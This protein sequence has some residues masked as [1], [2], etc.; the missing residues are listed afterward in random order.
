MAKSNSFDVVSKTDLNEVLNAVNQVMKEVRTR[1]DF[2]GSSSSVQL[3]NQTLMLAGD[4]AYKLQSLTEILQQKLVKRGVSLKALSYGKVENASGGT[5]RQ[6]I[7]IQQGIPTEKAREI[8]KFVRD[9]KIKVQAS[10]QGDLVRVS[11]RDRDTLQAVI[12][13]L[14]EKDFGI[15]MHFTNYRSS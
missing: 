5:V 7:S 6:Q 15:D 3:E 4:D 2:K 13:E 1:F 12:R 9:L 11:G 14:K 10:I 8:S